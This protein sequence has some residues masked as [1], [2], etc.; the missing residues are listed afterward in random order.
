MK[1]CIIVQTASYKSFLHLFDRNETLEDFEFGDTG[2]KKEGYV[3]KKIFNSLHR[4]E[5]ILNFD[6][7]SDEP[8]IFNA[9]IDKIEIEFIG[10]YAV[11]QYKVCG[12]DFKLRVLIN[13]MIELNTY[14]PDSYIYSKIAPL[15]S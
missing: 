10:N 5:D 8:I 13:K 7:D 3:D 6:Y 15:Y 14:N 1:A 4:V 11:C 9:K 2:Y 12:E